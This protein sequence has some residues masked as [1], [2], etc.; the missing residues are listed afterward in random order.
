MLRTTGSILT[1]RHRYFGVPG[2]VCNALIISPMSD[3]VNAVEDWSNGMTG[4]K[5]QLDNYSQA[6]GPGAVIVEGRD[7]STPDMRQFRDLL[8]DG[9]HEAVEQTGP[10][11]APTFPTDS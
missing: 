9:Y 1:G 10:G 5:A 3:R 6:A 8:T 11:F 7:N 4:A 2:V